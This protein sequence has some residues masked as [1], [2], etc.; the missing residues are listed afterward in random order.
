MDAMES[1][2]SEL[3]D[4]INTVE[5]TLDSIE[6]EAD[7]IATRITAIDSMFLFYIYRM[8]LK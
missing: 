7:V 8:Y 6:N 1:D 4:K 3:G 2:N 5:S